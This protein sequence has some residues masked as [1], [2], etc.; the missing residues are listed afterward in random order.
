MLIVLDLLSPRASMQMGQISTMYRPQKA[1]RPFFL[2][3]FA[4][5]CAALVLGALFLFIDLGRPDRVLNLFFKPTLSYLTFGTYALSAAIVCAGFLAVAWVDFGNQ[6]GLPRRLVRGVEVI[7][8]TSAI[9]VML[10]TGLLLYSI[11]TGTLLGSPIVPLL[12]ILSALSCGFALIFAATSLARSANL[13]SSTLLQLTRIDRVV[14]LLELV[15][16]VSLLL[17]YLFGSLGSQQQPSSADGVQSLLWGTTATT[18]AVFWLAL[19]AGGLLLPLVLE[20]TGILFLR[21]RLL[22]IAG[23]VLMGG[24]ALRWILVEVGLPAVVL[25]V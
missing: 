15:A 20:S 11:G 7:G 19:V 2:P 21:C 24:F 25:G 6:G 22:A 14:V 9:A 4:A 1:Y 5:C 10:Y 18:T 16:L 17:V 23:A 13:F 3:C 8:I 12:F